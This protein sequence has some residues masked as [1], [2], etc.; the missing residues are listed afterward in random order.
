MCVCLSRCMQVSFLPPYMRLCCARTRAS[1]RRAISRRRRGYHSTWA[2]SAEVA[3]DPSKVS[4]GVACAEATPFLRPRPL[5]AAAGAE[6]AAAGPVA[7]AA[8]EIQSTSG[9]CRHQWCQSCTVH[10]TVY[11]NH[12]HAQIPPSRSRYPCCAFAERTDRPPCAA[13]SRGK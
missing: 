4:L 11:S 7:A 2:T 3:A 8:R 5:E 12:L 1:F 10:L 9:S 13:P 6:G